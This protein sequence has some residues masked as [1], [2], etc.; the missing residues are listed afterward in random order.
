MGCLFSNFLVIATMNNKILLP[1][2]HHKSRKLDDAKTQVSKGLGKLF[3]CIEATKVQ[4]NIKKL[5]AVNCLRSPALLIKE[6]VYNY[7]LFLYF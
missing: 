3:G 2:K 5:Y 1:Q 4:Q 6:L 7:Y